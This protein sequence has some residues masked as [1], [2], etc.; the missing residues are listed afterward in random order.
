MGGGAAHHA[1]EIRQGPLR[2]ESPFCTNVCFPVG[3]GAIRKV[4]CG[5]RRSQGS[6][7]FEAERSILQG[8]PA[9]RGICLEVQGHLL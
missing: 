6:M 3:F 7:R 8:A 2:K 1:H 9:V 5:L 4:A